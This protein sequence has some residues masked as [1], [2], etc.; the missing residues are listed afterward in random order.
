[1]LAMAQP[2]VPRCADTGIKDECMT[3]VIAG[4]RTYIG[5]YKKNKRNGNFA[6]RYTESNYVGGFSDG[7]KSGMGALT[8]SGKAP[9]LYVGEF[10]KGKR[11]GRGV[12][13]F[14]SGA[15][16]VGEYS[17][18][19]RNGR[20]IV[21]YGLKSA[22]VGD[23]VDN[24]KHGRG[25][26]FLRNGWRYV[27]EFSEGQRH[28]RGVLYGPDGSV[29]RSGVWEKGNLKEARDI[30]GYDFDFNEEIAGKSFAVF[31]TGEKKDCL[32]SSGPKGKGGTERFVG[33]HWK[34][35][36]MGA[37]AW[38]SKSNDQYAVAQYVD[39]RR[40]GFGVYRWGKKSK[41]AGDLYVGNFA[42]NRRDG[43]GV[44][45]YESGHSYIG[46]WV[47][48]KRTGRGQ[49]FWSAKSK[50]WAKDIYVGSFID[51]WRTGQ[52]AYLNANQKTVAVGEFN[53]NKL[54][55]PWVEYD[56]AGTKV[57]SGESRDGKLLTRRDI[58]ERRYP[59]AQFE[60]WIP[61]PSLRDSLQI[62]RLATPGTT[63]S[64]SETGI[65]GKTTVVKSDRV[66]RAAAQLA[67][68]KERLRAEQASLREMRE[69]VEAQKL[70]E[71][72]ARIKQQAAKL[73]RQREEMAAALKEADSVRDS[74]EDSSVRHKVKK[75][76][77]V[78]G[79]STYQVGA[80]PNPVNDAQ[81]VAKELR[82]QGFKVIRRDNVTLT[83]IRSALRTFA[84]EFEKSDVGL[85]YYSG[86]G[87]E[88]KGIN[89]LIPVD[90]STIQREYELEV[91]AFPASQITAM[92][93]EVQDAD[94]RNR[95]A[96]L[97][98]DACRNNPLR[99]SFRSATVG[100][101]RMDAPAGTF[102]SFSTSPGTVAL[103]GTGRNSPF[104]KHLLRAMRKPNM[105]IERVFKEVRR[106]VMRETDN[107]Q[108]PWESSSLTGDFFFG[109]SN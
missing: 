21:S 100:L 29:K 57:G 46:E 22:Y 44:Y 73:K 84:S 36:R 90:N 82:Q 77:L 104:T 40:N 7:Q 14:E 69:A 108:V 50:K 6:V 2:T 51:N 95:V 96:I 59:I 16:Y 42:N 79:N 97:I 99:R 54:D 56:L 5:E 52:G 31:C 41:G 25:A 18:G 30:R 1:M 106:A 53:K 65:P 92:M 35:K 34:G 87:V 78:I 23:F 101:A 86:H 102:I 20:F 32:I 15:I 94:E 55:G 72:A 67:K 47:N 81:D 63:S 64:P 13:I 88:S 93:E 9:S 48:G 103:D 91:G 27:G 80:L 107:T 37:F 24:K 49:Y 38:A 28:G 45:A 8:Y 109:V 17:R 83:D 19:R 74:V 39:G 26:S 58:A 98:L 4:N 76:A 60:S 10:F 89:Y 68:E 85:V 66:A 62:T 43:V 71:Q 61:V 70:T 11:K 33:E 12:E 3:Q 75:V 105:P